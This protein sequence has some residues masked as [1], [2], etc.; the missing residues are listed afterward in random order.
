[1]LAA[2]HALKVEDLAIG[3]D[4]LIAFGLAPG[5]IFGEVLATALERVVEDPSLNTREALLALVREELL[6]ARVG[7]ATR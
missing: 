2:G 7:D 1:M 4:D 3:G 5:P 6:P